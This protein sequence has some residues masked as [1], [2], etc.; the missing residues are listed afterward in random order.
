MLTVREPNDLDRTLAAARK[1]GL[2]IGFVPT[3]GSLHEGHEALVLES[4]R[5]C[6]LTVVSI[7]VNPLQFE[8]KTAFHRYPRP[9]AKDLRKLRAWKADVV[10]C[11]AQRSFPSSAGLRVTEKKI[12]GIYE[13]AVR[14][15]HFEGV[16]TVVAKLFLQVRPTHAFFGEKDFQQLWLVEK[17]A[18]ELCIGVRIVAVPTVREYDTGLACSSRNL[19]LRRSGR[20]RA[21]WMYRAL[22]EALLKAQ[23]VRS[24]SALT[25]YVRRRLRSQGIRSEYVAIVET[26]DFSSPRRLL[27]TGVPYRML[28]AA[29]IDGVHLIDNIPLRVHRL[30]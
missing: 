23:R 16:L 17:M 26:R 20:F 10:Y 6:R 19:R 3:M 8:S 11:P 7:F 15:G 25:G 29:K 2:S 9:L 13:G 12:S 21:G 18:E 24:P 5:A 28:V 1:R 27:E 30:P 4:R 22:V 14:P